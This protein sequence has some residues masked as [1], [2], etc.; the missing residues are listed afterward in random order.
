MNLL[1][2]FIASCIYCWTLTAN[3]QSL[4]ELEGQLFDLPDVR[5]QQ[6]DEIN[7]SPTYE[8]WI[9]Q[10]L[11]HRHPEKGHFRQRIQLI[12][13]GAD[14]P[15]VLNTNGYQLQRGP[16]E[17]IELF[18]ANYI[19]VE[20][21]YFG[22]SQPD[23]LEWQYLTMR[24]IAAD[25]HHV[26]SLLGGIY[27]GPWVSTGISKG[28]E[29]STYYRYFYPDD[30][31]A[32]IAYVAPFPNDLKDQRIY[33]FLDTVGTADCRQ[34]ILEYQITLLENKAELL[35]LFKYFV[36]GKGGQFKH[37]GGYE[38]A[39][40]IIVME[41]PFTHFQWGGD[42]DRIPGRKADAE[43]LIDPLLLN[44][45]YWYLF[46]NVTE[47]LAAHYYQHATELGYYGY[48]TQP[49]GTGIEQWDGEVSACFFPFAEDLPY[50]PGL[51]RSLTKWLQSEASNIA[52]IYGSQDPWTAAQPNTG[53][54]KKVVKY[55][56]VG[57]HHGNARIKEMP[58]E[59][60]QELL[61]VVGEWV[62]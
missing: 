31:A 36:M 49:F 9:K 11:D 62:K 48:Q 1:K 44:G 12:H 18:D 19:S 20:H 38:A 4:T 27:A 42:C 21:R 24:Q 40:E 16:S 32:T 55:I 50:D 26:K 45:D 43:A 35:P 52:F 2:L 61:K 17:L 30:V 59:M 15:V 29:T 39:Y 7:N 54:N 8:L 58:D 33:A 34:R 23:S 13:R 56:L 14:K 51:Q 37:L 5:F 46:D 60:R 57:K 28:G 3:A 25:Y 10:P 41:L 22:E 53:S 6:I 47:N